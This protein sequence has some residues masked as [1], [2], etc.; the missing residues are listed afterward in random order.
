M[1][2]LA[3]Y[4]WHY[5]ETVIHAK[6]AEIFTVV[7]LAPQ[8]DNRVYIKMKRTLCHQGWMKS[9]LSV[10]GRSSIIDCHGYVGWYIPQS[11]RKT[12]FPWA[13]AGETFVSRNDAK[14]S[15]KCTQHM[16][17]AALLLYISRWLVKCPHSSCGLNERM[18]HPSHLFTS[19]NTIAWHTSRQHLK[20]EYIFVVCD[21]LGV[22]AYTNVDLL[23]W[24]WS[25]L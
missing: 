7:V 5:T 10:C 25:G 11:E 12:D 8:R 4:G 2:L 17:F 13:T 23:S 16:I 22:D 15:Y 14:L 24:W 1:F 20:R 19:M 9:V 3:V 21:I 6:F 18:E